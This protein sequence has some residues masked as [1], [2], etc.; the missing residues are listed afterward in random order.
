MLNL[1]EIMDIKKLEQEGYS[2]KGI[3]R[4][5][6]YARN[7]VRSMLRGRYK[8]KKDRKERKSI[9]DPYKDYVE[10]K[11]KD[12]E[13]TIQR[14]FEDITQLGYAGS[15]YQIYRFLLKNKRLPHK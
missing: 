11:F 6:G 10:D 12:T 13:L 3:V 2:I 8:D 9:L 4:E 5:T 14:I 15:I 1:D 7:T